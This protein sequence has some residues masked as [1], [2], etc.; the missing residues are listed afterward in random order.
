[1]ADEKEVEALFAHTTKEHGGVDVVVHAAGVMTLAPLKDF[2]LE[3]FDDMQ[4]INVRGTFVVDQQAAKQVIIF[5]LP[6]F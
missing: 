4:R 2:K 1:V 5:P 6:Y 3:D